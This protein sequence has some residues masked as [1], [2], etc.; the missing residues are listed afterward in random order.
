M[1]AFELLKG[2]SRRGG[3]PRCM[4]QLDLQR[5]FDMVDWHALKIILKEFGLP[6]K[7]ISWIM[8]TMTTVSYRF[9]LNGSYT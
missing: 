4:M 2:Y 8:V 7:F 1:L 6:W 9:N 3:T 5:A